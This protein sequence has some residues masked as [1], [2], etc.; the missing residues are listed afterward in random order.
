MKTKGGVY[1]NFFWQDGYGAFSVNPA[2]TENLILYLENQKDHH[3]KES[4]QDEYRQYLG[5]YRVKYD[6]R[7]VWD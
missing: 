3:A 5:R 7:Y 4:F 6:E 2:E 1:E